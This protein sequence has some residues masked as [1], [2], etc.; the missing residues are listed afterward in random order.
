MVCGG[1]F[2]GLYT[3]GFC[4][5]NHYNYI[6]LSQRRKRIRYQRRDHNLGFKCPLKITCAAK[7]YLVLICRGFSELFASLTT[8][9]KWSDILVGIGFVIFSFVVWWTVIWTVSHYLS[10]EVG[11]MTHGWA[12]AAWCL[13][14]VCI[15]VTKVREKKWNNMTYGW[16]QAR[17]W[18]AGNEYIFSVTVWLKWSETCW[19]KKLNMTWVIVDISYLCWCP[20]CICYLL[21]YFFPT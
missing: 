9:P 13:N 20:I 14:V 1:H 19:S 10:V 2:L 15:W 4:E 21:Y 3:K 5:R 12:Q 6:S 17:W 8:H 18:N 7:S 16:V 11:R